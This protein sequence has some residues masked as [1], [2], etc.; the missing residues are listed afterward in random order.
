MRELSSELSKRISAEDVEAAVRNAVHEMEIEIE[1]ALLRAESMRQ[2]LE[3]NETLLK[4]L[5]QEWDAERDSLCRELAHVKAQLAEL[6]Q[7][8]AGDRTR[9]AKAVEKV[10]YQTP[11]SK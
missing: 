5:Q 9:F 8:L 3:T 2:E 1:K 4:K 6:Q 7:E 11:F 10:I